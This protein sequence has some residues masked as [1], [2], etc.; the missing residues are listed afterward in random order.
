MR[1]RFIVAT[2]HDEDAFFRGSLLA[3]SLEQLASRTGLL[4]EPAFQSAAGLAAVYA[5]HRTLGGF[6]GPPAKR[7]ATTFSTAPRKY[8]LPR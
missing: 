2:R 3:Q 6:S 5:L 1:T 7:R 4:L 8:R